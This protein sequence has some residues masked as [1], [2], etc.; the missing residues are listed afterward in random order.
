MRL[1]FNCGRMKDHGLFTH[2]ELNGA[3]FPFDNGDILD[4]TVKVDS[5]N[6]LDCSDIVRQLDDHDLPDVFIK[7]FVDD[8]R[9][10]A[11]DMII[12]HMLRKP[13]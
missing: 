1:H 5:G 11:N 3:R 12:F 8:L 7:A 10:K 4:I 2:L 6:K 13:S 9:E